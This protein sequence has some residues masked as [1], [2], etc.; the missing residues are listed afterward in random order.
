MTLRV[1][2]QMDPVENSLDLIERELDAADWS[3]E[4]D[5]YNSIHCIAPTCWGD[6]GGV[7]TMQESPDALHFSVTLD[8]KPTLAR[9]GE[10]SELVI[11]MNEKLWLGHFDYWMADGIILFRHTIPM[12]GRTEPEASEVTAVIEAAKTA[13]ERF[14]PSLNYVIW[15]GKSAED[16]MVAAMFDTVG[17]A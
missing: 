3:H 11:L 13:V 8:V 4:R 6:L 7:F 15:A 2:D 16:A 12:A 1:S 10:V 5:G 9:R 14:T 17:E